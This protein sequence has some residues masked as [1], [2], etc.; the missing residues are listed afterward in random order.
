M[1]NG[2]DTR[3]R[4]ER[5]ALKLFATKGVAATSIRDIA[6]AAGVSLGAMYN[7]YPSK[8][9]LGWLLFS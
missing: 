1:R 2:T 5:A 8:D 7:H 6:K 9:D 4:I 3:E